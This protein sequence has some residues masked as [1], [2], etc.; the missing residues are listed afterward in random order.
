MTW[1]FSGDGKIHIDE[2]VENLDAM[3]IHDIRGEELMKAFELFDR[4]K[5]G[6]I[7][8]GSIYNVLRYL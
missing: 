5:S 1:I 3:V 8:Y 4:D 7:R 2:L 6:S